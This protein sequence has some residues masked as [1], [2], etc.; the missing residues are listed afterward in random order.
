MIPS[1]GNVISV[2]L[3]L[4]ICRNYE[5]TYLVER[6][7]NNQDAFKEWTFDGASILPDEIFAKIFSVPNLIEIALRHDLKYAYGEPDNKSERL[8]ADE[9]FRRDLLNDGCIS[10]VAQA[11]YLAVRAFGNFPIKTDF[12]WGFARK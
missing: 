9:Q 8:L 2:A 3:A 1:I 5:F 6:L 7:S 4:E 10:G 12:S 11:M